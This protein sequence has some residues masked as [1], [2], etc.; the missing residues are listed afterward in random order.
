MYLKLLSN[1]SEEERQ[2]LK[3]QLDLSEKLFKRIEKCIDE[4]V[5]KLERS[6]KDFSNPS[7][8]YQEAFIIGKKE[9]LTFLKTLL[10][11]K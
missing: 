3:E 10:N 5:E 1:L 8:A 4:E 6:E 7:W 9:G 11:I 2:T